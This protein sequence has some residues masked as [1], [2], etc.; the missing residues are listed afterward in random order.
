MKCTNCGNEF[1]GKFCPECGASATATAKPTA[2]NPP[3][4]APKKKS[5]C[6]K[7]VLI[8]LLIFVVLA[9]IGSVF[10]EPSASPSASTTDS[11]SIATQSSSAASE[12]EPTYIE[13]TATDL[14]AAYAANTVSADNQYLDQALKVTGT[15][16]TIGKDVL[17][18]AYVT[19]TDDNDKYS[20]LSVQCYFD[21]DNLDDIATLK[22]GD[23]VTITGTCTGSLGNVL[24]KDCNVETK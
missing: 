11:K 23:I 22:E 19:L 7:I 16:G 13:V 1:E 18:Q 10:G 4:A 2:S 15:V 17:D 24:I 20:I 14:L 12:S 21:K 8:V 9:V 3:A 5:G 6:L